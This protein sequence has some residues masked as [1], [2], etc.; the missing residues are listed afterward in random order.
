MLKIVLFLVVFLIVSAMGLAAAMVAVR[1]SE[2][3]NRYFIALAILLFLF[4]V[5]VLPSFFFAQY[6]SASAMYSFAVDSFTRTVGL[7]PWLVK[8]TVVLLIVPFL[9][10][11]NRVL[12]FRPKKRAAGIAVIVVYVSGYFFAMYFATKEVYFSHAEGE[13]VK[14]YAATPEGY[15]FFDSPGVDPKW[16][17][18]LQPVTPE[19]LRVVRTITPPPQ[20]DDMFFDPT[21]GANLRWYSTE[22]SGAFKL[23][24]HPGHN[25]A[26]GDSLFPVTRDIARLYYEQIG[27]LARQDSL[28]QETTREEE[29]I[30]D[31][32]RGE[33]VRQEQ[34][35]GRFRAL[36]RRYVNQ[37]N[38]LST[39][40]TDLT[41]VVCERQGESLLIDVDGSN[42][43]GN[44]LR[45]T[46]FEVFGSPFTDAFI[47]D[48]KMQE[49][50]SG[51]GHI[52]ARL[53]SGG[54]ADFF[55]IGVSTERYFEPEQLQGLHSCEYSVSLK[56]FDPRG[57][58][59]SSEVFSSTGVGIS[60]A[61]AKVKA[62]SQISP[63][64]AR[65]LESLKK[66]VNP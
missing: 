21:T 16:G 13:V 51:N 47:R 26:T 43:I 61:A 32:I 12:S 34:Q 27:R 50:I 10:A 41:I 64:V 3:R 56:V 20:D 53:E 49:L 58:L 7:N 46:G 55:I 2:D 59:R 44:Q 57:A 11:M 24:G 35:E 9:W 22:V 40:K 48:G 23:F 62:I 33:T 29:R 15:R 65:S 18:D 30:R 37:D 31:S 17:I 19:L 14:W 66:G 38:V 5:F 6:L 36:R 63:D 54:L 28:K 42:Q 8:A 39:S 60:T 25:P 1:K 45:A 52:L 4:L